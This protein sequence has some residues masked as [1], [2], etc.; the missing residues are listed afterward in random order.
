[1][2]MLLSSFVL[3]QLLSEIEVGDDDTPLP[4][5]FAMKTIF[6]GIDSM[7]VLGNALNIM[8]KPFASFQ[9]VKN[10]F[11][12]PY[13]DWNFA[14]TRNLI[15]GIKAAKFTNDLTEYYTGNPLIPDL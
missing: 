13:G 10:A 4:D 2:T 15:P 6:R 11:V 14:N 5:T 7:F 8:T 3:Q 1:M 9:I 12:N